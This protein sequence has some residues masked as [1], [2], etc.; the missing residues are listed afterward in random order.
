MWTSKRGT[1]SS[2]NKLVSLFF[3]FTDFV[4][5]SSPNKPYP[6]FSGLGFFLRFV[7]KFDVGNQ[8]QRGYDTRPVK[9]KSYERHLYGRLECI[10]RNSISPKLRTILP[11]S[12]EHWAS[13]DH[14]RF[15]R[16]YSN[17]STGSVTSTP[18]FFLSSPKF[19]LAYT[20]IL[21]G[22]ASQ[23]H[24]HSSLCETFTASCKHFVAGGMR[25]PFP[26]CYCW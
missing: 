2:S 21:W 5:F 13:F 15:C 8:A 11:P 26:H 16:R 12:A 10:G 7:L 24:P 4:F 23:Q 14:L 18:I 3:P 25:P 17:L 22:F 20:F 6:Y 9:V 19:L 1:P